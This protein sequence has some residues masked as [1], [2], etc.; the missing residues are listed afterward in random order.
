MMFRLLALTIML[1]GPA[2]AQERMTDTQCTQTANGIASMIDLDVELPLLTIND[3]GWCVALDVQIPLSGVAQVF[4]ETVEWRASDIDRFLEQGLP[5]R[6][7][8]LKIDGISTAA[9]SGDPVFDY[10]IRVQ[11]SQSSLD[12][13]L[14][15]RWDGVQNAILLD[16]AY[17][18]FDDTNRIEAAG[19]VDGVDLTDFSTIQTNLG[20]AG[21]RNLTVKSTFDGWFE[22]FGAMILGPL[23]LQSGDVPPEDQV[24]ALQDLAAAQ[25]ETL[26]D[27]FMSAP[28]RMALTEFLN[29]LP[30]PQGRAQMQINADPV[31]GAARTAP[32]MMM[33]STPTMLE[34]VDRALNGVTVVFTWDEAGE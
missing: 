2:V 20:T 4:M 33:S 7:F 17:I 12:L 6:A 27:E 29:T 18:Q 19:R 21:L 10:L 22:G 13:G 25:I 26:P 1:A 34:V 31:I 3:E 5:P 30:N 11:S 15:A 14:S 23:V 28:S 8:E 24:I 9:S 32:I 16:D